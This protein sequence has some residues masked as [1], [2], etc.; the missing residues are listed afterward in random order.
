[1]RTTTEPSACFA[2][3]PV[4]MVMVLPSPI[5]NV[6]TIG[7]INF[8]ALGRFK[9]LLYNWNRKPRLNRGFHWLV[10]YFLLTDI[11]LAD[12]FSIA[13]D[14]CFLQVIKQASALAYKLNKG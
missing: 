2:S 10:L 7:F 8:V 9:G 1:M 11:Q 3:F 5:S 6:L 4:S 12:D 14:V 13:S